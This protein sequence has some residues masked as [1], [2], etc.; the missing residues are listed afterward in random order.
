MNITD[1]RNDM[2]LVYK[3]LREGKIKKADANALAST[4]GKMISSA[5][6]Q[7]EYAAMRN[8]K[9][10]IEFLESKKD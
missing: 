9:P 8:E 10:E 3:E 7:L 2:I 1:I 4:V 5:K 6:V